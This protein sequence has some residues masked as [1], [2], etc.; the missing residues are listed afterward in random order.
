[1]NDAKAL[2]LANS[3]VVPAGVG[4]AIAVLATNNTDL[5]ID[6]AGYFAP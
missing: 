4:G 6:A 5:V 3:A 1:L 2:P